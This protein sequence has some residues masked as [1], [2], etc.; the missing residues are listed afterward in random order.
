METPAHGDGE[1]DYATAWF[2]ECR[3]VLEDVATE[4]RATGRGDTRFRRLIE[5][6]PRPTTEPTGAEK[7]DAARLDF[8][9]ATPGQFSTISRNDCY[10]IHMQGMGYFS[11]LN[12]RA[13]IDNARLARGDGND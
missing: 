6:M 9:T 2:A 13:A 10:L 3:R 7:E 5:S 11:G 12:V 8:I 4:M 1:V